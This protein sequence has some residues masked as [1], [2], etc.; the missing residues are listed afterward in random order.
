M[1]YYQLSVAVFY[2]HCY[3]SVTGSRTT[4]ISGP[5]YSTTG[6]N[7][8]ITPASLNNHYVTRSGCLTG[9]SSNRPVV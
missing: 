4:D 7:V 3:T 8:L 5:I 1:L 9:R 2:T 6:V